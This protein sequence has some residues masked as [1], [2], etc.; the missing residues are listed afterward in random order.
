MWPLT[1]TVPKGLIPVAGTPF[2]D[3]QIGQLAAAGID[4]VFLA[5]GRFQL[6]QWERFAEERSGVR[7]I[8][9]DEPLDTAG[10]VRAGLG[11][12]DERFMV[13]NGDVIL[14]ADL[15]GFIA[16][17]DPAAGATLAL[18]EVDDTSAYGVVVLSDGIVERFVEKPPL[19]EAPAR[20]VN[21]GI[22]VM[23]QAALDRYE[24]GRLSFE[25][26]VFP[27]L[28]DR[29]ALG[30]VVIEGNWLDI[31][32]PDLYLDCTGAILSGATRLAPSDAAHRVEG[33]VDGS[34]EGEWSW[35]AAGATIEP[36]AVV[37]ETVVL[38]GA[39][40]SADANVRR[41]IIGWDATIGSGATVDG[42]SIVGIGATIG[43]GCEMSHGAR[44]APGA[45]LEPGAITFTPPQ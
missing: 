14:E 37:S 41:A 7:L 13:L 31:G 36:G 19:A 29:S 4:E 11:D 22:Y 8:V 30:G 6:A 38:P 44:A 27:D 3:F 34:L 16:A 17:A 15:S 18:V 28:V 35:I 10:P 25:R 1:A 26:R 39:V 21:A 40:V 43:S 45:S 23:S 32:T 9:E 20:T 42:G 33:R 12:L 2:L 5:V 24:P